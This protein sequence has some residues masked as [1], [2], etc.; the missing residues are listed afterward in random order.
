ELALRYYQSLEGTRL[1]VLVEQ[2]SDER[3]GHVRG[4]DRR[5]VPVELPGDASEFGKF[6]SAVGERTV[7]RC[8]CASRS[9]SGGPCRLPTFN[10]STSRSNREAT[11]S[12]SG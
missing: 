12:W 3:P 1:E 9:T 10:R 6:V 4:T 11:S 5:Y 2:A 8:L 7:N